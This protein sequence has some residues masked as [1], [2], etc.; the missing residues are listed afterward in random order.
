MGKWKHLQRNRQG[1]LVR[2]VPG[3]TWKKWVSRAHFGAV[4]A[5]ARDVTRCLPAEYTSDN[6]V[7]LIS[8]YCGR[9]GEWYSKRRGLCDRV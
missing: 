5:S 2:A 3:S 1:R 8:V 9:R 7:Y 6:F 4:R